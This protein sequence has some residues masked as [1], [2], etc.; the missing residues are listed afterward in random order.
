MTKLKPPE[1]PKEALELAL[2]LA[3]SAPDE[4][5]M[6]QAT[7]A[8]ISI[9]RTMPHEDVVEVLEILEGR[10]EMLERATFGNTIENLRPH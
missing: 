5:K 10:T 6:M 3:A 2:I 4:E 9:A 1:T 8:A 7:K